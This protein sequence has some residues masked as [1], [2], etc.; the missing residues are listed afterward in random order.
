VA[1]VQLPGGSVL[2]VTSPLPEG[3]ELHV[4]LRAERLLL[5]G[6]YGKGCNRSP[7]IP[8]LVDLNNRVGVK[9]DTAE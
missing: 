8:L 1:Q 7:S 9:G 6:E 5:P 2:P 4:A 3:P